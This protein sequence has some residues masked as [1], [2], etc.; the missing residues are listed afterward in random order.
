MHI[1]RITLV[2][3]RCFGEDPTTIEL[4]HEL[5]A[6]V[7][8]NSTGKTAAFAALGRLFGVTR[9]DRQ[10]QATDFH[11]PT[12]EATRPSERSL[13]IDVVVAFPEL[14]TDVQALTSETRSVPEFFR[15]MA[16]TVD[17]QLKCR[18]RLE[19]TR[20]DDG[21]IEGA[22]EDRALVVRS[23]EDDYAEDDCSPLRPMDRSRIQVIYV[24]ASRDGARHVTTF[25]R[26]R[27]WKA[28]QWSDALYTSVDEAAIQIS[29]HFRAE[30]VV[31]VIEGALE[32]RWRHLHQGRLDAEPRLRVIDRDLGDLVAKADLVFAPTE[33]GRERPAEQLSDG[34][35]SLLQ[36]ALT[37]ATIDIE[38]AIA[39]GRLVSHFDA[40]SVLLPSLTVLIVEEPENSLSPH[41]LAR[42]TSQLQDVSS[43][44]RAQ[45]LLSSHS[46]SVL[47]RVE[48]HSVRH[49]RLDQVSHLSVVNALPLPTDEH[50]E[51]TFVRAAVQA[52]P[53]LYFAR[54][55]VLGEGS[56]EEVVLPR[57]AE[58]AGTM[59]DQSFVA[60]VPLGGRHVSHFWRLLAGL[61]IPFATLLDLDLGRHG[62][63]DDRLRTACRE[64][65]ALGIDA[66]EGLE[67]FESINQIQDLDDSQRKR[68]L[69]SLEEHGVFYCTPLDLDMMM[70]KAFPEAY[71]FIEDVQ[72]G[73]RDSPA[74]EAVLGVVGDQQLYDGW[75]D[76]LRWYRYLFLGR[77]KPSTHIRAL[78]RL[79]PAT[80]AEGTPPPIDAVISRV[81]EALSN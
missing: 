69:E 2:N 54:F 34:Q 58:A 27:L 48:P 5:T 18:F 76:E 59:I 10:F 30:P 65:E 3:F 41:F 42:V 37:A 47:R 72:S 35:R 20:V 4:D 60:V 24:P 25:L 49:F 61:G 33:T 64:L 29:D 63:G 6:F 9:S 22:I 56:S 15:H 31:D 44:P 50:E 36:I 14:A 45:S 40:E 66:L 39:S 11:V 79:D 43:G 77:S 73:P 13:S 57:L 70:L 78:Q 16:A 17:G 8:A 75:D 28:G 68:V 81:A 32:R 7:G 62:G 1:E 55:V 74:R 23:F 21:S 19:A 52:F 26:S 51:A 71:K 46:A 67:E 80:L 12:Q 38:G 53:E